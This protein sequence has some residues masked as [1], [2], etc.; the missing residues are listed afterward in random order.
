MH[1]R[2]EVKNIRLRR[3]E[4]EMNG[5]KE[6]KKIRLD[7]GKGRDEWVDRSEQHTPRSMEDRDERLKEVTAMILHRWKVEMNR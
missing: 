1:G 4:V 3:W 6:A 7:R 5:Q 2:K